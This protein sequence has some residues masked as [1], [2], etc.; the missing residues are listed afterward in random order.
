MDH[1]PDEVVSGLID[2]SDVD[3]ADLAALDVDNPVL[4]GT[5]QQIHDE[6]EHSDEAV[7]GHQSSL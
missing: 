3:L 4:A 7:A 6:L 5:L 1:A 2:L